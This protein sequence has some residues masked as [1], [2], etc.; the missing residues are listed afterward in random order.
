MLSSLWD[1]IRKIF[2]KTFSSYTGSMNDTKTGPATRPFKT[3]V[4]GNLSSAS[5]ASFEFD[6]MPISLK[7]AFHSTMQRMLSRYK[8]ASNTAATLSFNQQLKNAFFWS[9]VPFS[10]PCEGSSCVWGS[11]PGH[12][13]A[14][15]LP[16]RMPRIRQTGAQNYHCPL[17]PSY[18]FRGETAYCMPILYLPRSPV[19]TFGDGIEI[20]AAFVGNSIQDTA[21]TIVQ[22]KL[23]LAPGEVVYS[24]GYGADTAEYAYLKQTHV[25]LALFLPENTL[26]FYSPRTIFLSSMRSQIWPSRMGR[27]FRSGL[28]S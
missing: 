14:P 3:S 26:N 7:S 21:V 4:Y 17:Q 1:F 9:L 24:S 5:S 28:P 16:R 27:S 18:P 10:R 15:G 2:Q 12:A 13:H 8:S 11:S 6:A 23:G 22:D 25:G 20:P 19:K